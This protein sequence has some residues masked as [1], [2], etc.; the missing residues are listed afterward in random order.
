MNRRDFIQQTSVTLGGSLLT[1]PLSAFTN[2]QPENLIVGHGDFKYSVDKE[3][4]KLDASSY[5]VN[6]CHEMVMDRKHRFI[7]LT[8]EPKNNILIYD[9]LGKL[10][11]TW[12]LNLAGAHGL[13]LHEENGE[14][15]LYITD[16]ILGEIYKTTITGRVLL[17]IK[18]P[19]FINQYQ[20]CDKFRPTETCIG[21]N[22]DIY[23]ADGYGSQYM[24]QYDNK[25]E[26]VRKFG[27][28][29]AIAEDKFKQAHGI[30]LDTRDSN[31]PTLLCTERMKNC[32]KR[33][34]LDGQYIESIYTPGAYL[35]RAVIKGDMLYSGVCYSALKHNY[36]TLNSGFVTILNKENKVVSNP[37][38]TA[39]VYLNGE[40]QMMVQ[41]QPIFKH[42]HD[43]CVDDE[44]NLYVPQW[45]AGK[46]YPFKLTK[47]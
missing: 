30:T 34:S 43:V 44:D 8:N 10:L 25:G 3:W 12:T 27:G 7:L 1:K 32:F 9:K 2:N 21:P 26:F 16:V 40:L 15:F 29:G 18:H 22:G 13:T 20:D 4:G 28:D 36:L 11:E 31:N 24:L 39:P 17:T 45:N 42:C 14:E 5:P 47:I 23:V 19:K 35:S 38:G 37:G 46:V 41:D 6:D 33:F